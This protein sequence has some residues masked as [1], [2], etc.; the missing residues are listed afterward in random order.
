MKFK[1]F[2]DW[3]YERAADGCWDMIES[4]VCISIVNEIRKEKFWRREKVWKEKYEEDI[5]NKIV[6][7]IEE[8]MK[9]CRKEY[10]L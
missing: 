7:P 1:E 3:C 4:I 9:E 2:V 6:H 8:K 5:L 10:S